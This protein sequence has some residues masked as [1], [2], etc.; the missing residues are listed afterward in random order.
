MSGKKGG[1]GEE[2]RER[3]ESAKEEEGEIAGRK[4]RS[5]LLPEKE[6]GVEGEE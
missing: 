4:A 2:D 6:E 1:H 5:F 3:R